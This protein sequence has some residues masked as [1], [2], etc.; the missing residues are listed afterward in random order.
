MVDKFV[1][2]ML[3]TV[4]V[5]FLLSVIAP[6]KS[7][8]K[9]WRIIHKIREEMDFV[10]YWFFNICAILT[11]TYVIWMGVHGWIEAYGF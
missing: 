5:L 3:V 7:E 8:R 11:V 1:A 9:F 10:C 6:M 2:V 4:F